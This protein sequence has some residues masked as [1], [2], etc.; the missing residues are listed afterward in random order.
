MTDGPLYGRACTCSR[1]SKGRRRL[2]RS[3]SLHSPTPH[4]VRTASRIWNATRYFPGF[5]TLH[6]HVLPRL[7]I[8][9]FPCSRIGDTLFF[10]LLCA[11]AVKAS[12]HISMRILDCRTFRFICFFI[13]PGFTVL[14]SWP[15]QPHIALASSSWPDKPRAG[16]TSETLNYGVWHISVFFNWFLTHCLSFYFI[17]DTGLWGLAYFDLHLINAFSTERVLLL[18]RVLCLSVFAL[19]TSVLGPN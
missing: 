10:L 18:W 11:V 4:Y 16:L 15:Y 13:D 8:S 7:L 9:M 3:H 2:I 5:S 14:S 17:N 1:C 19:C 6:D 12:L